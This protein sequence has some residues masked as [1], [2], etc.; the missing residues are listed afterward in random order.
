MIAS[1]DV[2]EALLEGAESSMGGSSLA[3]DVG[4][5]SIGVKARRMD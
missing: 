1:L 4:A 2:Q 5:G 3:R